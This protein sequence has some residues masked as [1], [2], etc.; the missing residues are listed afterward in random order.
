[1][2]NEERTQTDPERVGRWEYLLQNT[3][4][5]WPRRKA[6]A[7]MAFADSEQ[8]AL[9]AEV[10]RLRGLLGVAEVRAGWKARAE[11]AESERDGLRALLL[12]ETP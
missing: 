1:M 5:Y 9:V 7:V 11:A 4:S 6:E 8:A 2:T 3:A 10:E 12:E